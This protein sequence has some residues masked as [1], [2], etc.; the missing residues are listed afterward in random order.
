MRTRWRTAAVTLGALAMLLGA[1]MAAIA[2]PAAS[3]TSGSTSTTK[4]SLGDYAWI[5][6]PLR[7][8][9]KKFGG[10]ATVSIRPNGDANCVGKVTNESYHLD[11]GRTVTK[12]VGMDVSRNGSCTREASH[13]SWTVTIDQGSSGFGTST[14][15][16]WFGQYNVGSSYFSKCVGWKYETRNTERAWYLDVPIMKDGKE[17]SFD[18]SVCKSDPN[19]GGLNVYAERKPR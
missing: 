13:Q 15:D 8:E 17:D 2:A 18:R 14:F 9:P 4:S 11:L 6:T 10:T 16:I 5:T 7:I 19:T 1:P 12:D 3:A